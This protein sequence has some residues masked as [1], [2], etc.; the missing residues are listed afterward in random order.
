MGARKQK[1][2]RAKQRA[3]SAFQFWL[4][5]E[6]R[7]AC[8]S[9]EWVGIPDTVDQIYLENILVKRGSAI[10]FKD[11]ITNGYYCG[12]NSSG[13]DE[14][15]YGYPDYRVVTMRNGDTFR[16]ATK[17]SVIIYNNSFRESD[18]PYMLY[19]ADL[20][21]EYT[22]AIRVNVQTQKTMPILPA[23]QQQALAIEQTYANIENNIP[24][25]II[26]PNSINIES[27]KNALLFDN[28]KS[29]TADLIS[30]VKREEWNNFLTFCG[31]DNSNID[32]KAQVNV[33][34][35]GS[36]LEEVL[37]MK[38]SKLNSR[39]EGCK[40]MKMKWGLN[41]DVKY[42]GQERGDKIGNL[43]GERND[44]MQTSVHDKTSNIKPDINGKYSSET[45]S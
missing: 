25:T 38:R 19:V 17:D 20:M 34:E 4:S 1:E 36:N 11:D 3:W 35:S 6:L 37:Y 5:R 42:Y 14:D 39:K 16:V 21:S 15:W 43:Y 26:D 31:I 9:I 18:M 30:S 23:N 8:S 28:R 40:L 29:F 13:G 2:K 7:V 22:S 41:V 44:D 24:Y 45:N 33:L 27:I 10:I 32:K 12:A